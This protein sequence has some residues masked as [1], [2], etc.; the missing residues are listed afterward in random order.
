VFVYWAL[1]KLR[2]NFNFLTMKKTLQ[3]ILVLI[4]LIMIYLGIANSI[5]PPA[6]TG[7]GF[8]VIALLFK[9]KN[10]DTND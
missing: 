7:V 8:I 3:I 10:N 9:L 2:L 6:L 5:L 4:A 1:A